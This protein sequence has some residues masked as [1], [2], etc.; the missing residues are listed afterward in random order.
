MRSLAGRAVFASK[1]ERGEVF[2]AFEY[3]KPG[4]RLI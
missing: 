1:I 4:K 3:E 2:T